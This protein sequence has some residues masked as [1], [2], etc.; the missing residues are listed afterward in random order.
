MLSPVPNIIPRNLYK[1]SPDVVRMSFNKTVVQCLYISCVCD[2]LMLRDIFDA[3]T[4]SHHVLSVCAISFTEIDHDA[5][6]NVIGVRYATPRSWHVR[7]PS[8]SDHVISP[9]SHLVILAFHIHIIIPIQVP[10]QFLE[11][12]A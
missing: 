6:R 7:M 3:P 9:P 10:C 2:Y 1:K 12:I 4:T 5:I 11:P 8:Y